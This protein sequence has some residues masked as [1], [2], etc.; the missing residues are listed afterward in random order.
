VASLMTK[1]CSK[2]STLKLKKSQLDFALIWKVIY[3]FKVKLLL[4][5]SSRTNLFIFQRKLSGYLF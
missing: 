1:G 4:K 5:D 2:C 3:H